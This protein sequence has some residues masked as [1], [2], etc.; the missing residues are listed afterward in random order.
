MI[1]NHPTNT[2]RKSSMRRKSLGMT[3][4]EMMIVVAIA[5]GLLASLIVER[6]FDA[7]IKSGEQLAT[8]MTPYFEAV[9]DYT[10]KFRQE[11]QLGSPITG[12]ANAYQPTVVE[13]KALNILA[14]TYAT[15]ISRVG[16]APL[17][18][19][20]R[21]PV[22]CVALTCDLS[23]MVSTSVPLKNAD[24]T[25]AEGVLTYATRK[26]GGMAGYSEFNAPAIF[27]G[28]GGWTAPNPNGAVP[29]IFALYTT[30][31]ASGE[32]R[33][34]VV[35]E[36][37]DPNF[38]NNVTVG[39]NIIVPTGTIG[40]GTGNP[41]GAECRLGEILASGA[42]WSRSATCIKR[43]WVDGSSGEIG[44]A[45]AAGNTRASMNDTGEIV[46][47]DALGN[48]KAGM[49]Y[50]NIAG[51]TVSK[52]SA[53][54]VET[55]AGT[56]GLR[57]NGEAFS[58]T[59]V[60]NADAAPGAACPT[61]K[62]MIWGNGANNLKLLKCVANVWTTTGATV[63][64]IGGACATNGEL[65]ETPARVSIIC[66]GGTWQTTTSRMGSWAVSNQY[67]VGHGSVVPKPTCGS[68]STPKIIAVPKG[69][70]ATYVLQNFDVTDNGPSW[71]TTMTG[72]TAGEIAWA[73]AIAQVGCWYP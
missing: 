60:I 26:I 16:G 2:S 46:S 57:P 3:L 14:S 69:I 54:L 22:G 23:Y 39:G 55:N 7:R 67:F 38:I 73:T 72:P 27:S 53:D 29:G 63:G 62:A 49:T 10:R 61:N 41:G 33:F 51:V 24:G 59:V 44:V 66:V 34:L 31:S 6:K 48:I 37:R 36:T 15:T 19:V 25:A 35:N 42:F 11:L 12:V 32:A 40:T 20:E 1:T 52:V 9:H 21:L 58:D 70:N 47:R 4:V 8:T 71:T 65:G 30:Y 43:A 64:A 5:G 45:D 13:M 50:V 68:G 17:Y 18:R 28:S 56:A